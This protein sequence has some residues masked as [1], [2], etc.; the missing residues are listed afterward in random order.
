MAGHNPDRLRGDGDGRTVSHWAFGRTRFH[1]DVACVRD[2]LHRG[3]GVAFHGSRDSASV[4]YS[5]VLVG[6]SPRR[7]VLLSVDVWSA[8]GHVGAAHRLDGHWLRH[9]FRLWTSPFAPANRQ[10]DA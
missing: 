5:D 3:D 8:Y 1:W 9:L 6:L 2:C 7:C 4:S 10:C